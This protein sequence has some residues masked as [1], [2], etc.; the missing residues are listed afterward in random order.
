[1]SA[2][3]PPVPP[4]PG[5]GAAPNNT[6]GLVALILGIA[7]IPLV[8]CFWLGVPVGIAAAVLGFIG[9]GKAERGEATNRGQALAGM[10]CGIAAVAL[11]ILSVIATLASTCR[12]PASSEP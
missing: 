2:P 8:C 5:P 7:A 1:V 12:C 3:Y 11:G 6:L 4:A 9:K 10:I